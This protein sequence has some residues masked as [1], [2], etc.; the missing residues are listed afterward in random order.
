MIMVLILLHFS[1]NT[2][3]SQYKIGLKQEYQYGKK[4][5]HPIK[6]TI[7]RTGGSWANMA[8]IRGG[9]VDY[10]NGTKLY[11]ILKD[12]NLLYLARKCP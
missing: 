3:W 4:G 1:I 7:L 9:L 8:A 2:I 10:G 11:K 6:N 12:K 5:I